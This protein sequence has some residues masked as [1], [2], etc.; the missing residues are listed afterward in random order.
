VCTLLPGL[1]RWSRGSSARSAG[2]RVHT[3]DGPG[4][5]GHHGGLCQLSPLTAR[6]APQFTALIEQPSGFYCSDQDPALQSYGVLGRPH[7]AEAPPGEKTGALHAAVD[8]QT[9]RL[10]FP[11]TSPGV[12][13]ASVLR[14]SFSIL[15]AP[16]PWA[17]PAC[18]EISQSVGVSATGAPTA[19]RPFR[20]LVVTANRLRIS[21]G[22]ARSPLYS[23]S[24]HHAWSATPGPKILRVAP[25]PHNWSAALSMRHVTDAITTAG[26]HQDRATW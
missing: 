17:L 12:T 15:A 5:P 8:V 1:T 23:S 16:E 26:S 11:I 6:A 9:S 21:G 10:R 22:P 13:V 20:L 4:P 24:G 19:A 3:H 14:A 7:A 2:L 18:L 25:A